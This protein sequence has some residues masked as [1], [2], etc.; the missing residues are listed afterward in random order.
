M[1]VYQDTETGQLWSFNDHEDPYSMSN[2]NIPKTLSEVVKNKP[3]ASS[4]WFDGDWIS[5]ELAPPDYTPPVSSVPSYNPAWMAYLRPY[6][7]IHRDINS[8]LAVTL[9]QINGNSY[10][11]TKLAEVIGILP[12]DIPSGIPALV[13][14]DGA[15][16]VPQ[17]QDIPSRS[18]GLDKLTEIFCS[19][20][21]GGVHAEALSPSDL[22]VGMLQDKTQLVSCN[23]SLHMSLRLNWA[24]LGDRVMPLT[25]PRVLTYKDLRCA[26]DRGQKTLRALRDLAPA[27][28]LNGYTGMV[29]RND[30][31]ALSNLWIAVEQITEIFLKS[32]PVKITKKRRYKLKIFDKHQF[33]CSEKIITHECLDALNDLRRARNDLAHQGIV[34]TPETVKK[35]WAVLAQLIT[36]ASGNEVT[37]AEGFPG[38]GGFDAKAPPRTNFDEWYEVAT[39]FGDISSAKS[40]DSKGGD[41]TNLS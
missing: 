35:L 36:L 1:K 10:D 21:L 23:L 29:Y 37:L 11:G 31:D 27:I 33:L 9:D 38:R 26:Y 30:R 12:L 39:K 34:P 3:D 19:L 8:S 15:I 24:S 17:C 20:V 41:D 28:L 5:R 18:D 40:N 4:V 14:Y 13:S 6:T 32:H 16:A 25:C 2:R 7:A 22:E